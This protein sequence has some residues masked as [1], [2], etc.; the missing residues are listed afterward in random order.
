MYRDYF[1]SDLE[2]DPEDADVEDRN[3]DLDL[4]AEGQ[5]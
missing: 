1:E 2:I 3:D 5:F 4:A